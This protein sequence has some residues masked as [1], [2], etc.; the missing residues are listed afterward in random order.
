M[1]KIEVKEKKIRIA[2]DNTWDIVYKIDYRFP[3]D[4]TFMEVVHTI[5]YTPKDDSKSKIKIL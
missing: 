1:R 5:I 4:T 2:F 3:L